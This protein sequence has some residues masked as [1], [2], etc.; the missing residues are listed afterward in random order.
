MPV[1]NMPS[2]IHPD[3][4]TEFVDDLDQT[5]RMKLD[6]S[7]IPSGTLVKLQVPALSGEQNLLVGEYD[8]DLGAFIV[9]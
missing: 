6:L 2:P 4:V 9:K 1:T 3:D 8:P 7:Q 5:K